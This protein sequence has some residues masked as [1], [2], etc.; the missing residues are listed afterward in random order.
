MTAMLK[1]LKTH[2][3]HTLPF[4]DLNALANEYPSLAVRQ[5]WVS[6]EDAHARED[7]VSVKR[8][9]KLKKWDAKVIQLYG[10]GS[11]SFGD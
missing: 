10:H 4:A 3:P 6:E 1:P 11:E 8:S 9:G 2:S 5:F 7:W